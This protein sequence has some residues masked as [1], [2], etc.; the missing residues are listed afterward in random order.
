[1]FVKGEVRAKRESDD[2]KM[3]F[4]SVLE[5]D[6][7]VQAFAFADAPGLDVVQV[8]DQVQATVR[9]KLNKAQNGVSVQVRTLEVLEVAG[10]RQ[11]VGV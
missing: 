8:G 2:R 3:F 10:E 7:I 5:Q 4:L 6:E 1:M 9:V 11:L